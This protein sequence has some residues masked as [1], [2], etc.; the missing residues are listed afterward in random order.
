[1]KW[2]VQMPLVF[3]YF[4]LLFLAYLRKYT[5]TGYFYLSKNIINNTVTISILFLKKNVCF[6]IQINRSIKIVIGKFTWLGNQ[7][8]KKVTT[9]ETIR[10]ILIYLK[11]MFKLQYST[12]HNLCLIS[13][14]YCEN[15]VNDTLGFSL[16][17]L[18]QTQ[19][20]K[21]ICN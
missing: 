5:K 14:D 19:T 11:I 4:S 6:Q 10:I 16:K 8:Q 18:F 17:K 3:F 21:C 1:M 13:L 20:T 15:S 9:T 2:L 12:F 7:M